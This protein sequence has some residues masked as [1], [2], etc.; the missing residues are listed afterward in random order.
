M[1]P[2][3]LPALSSKKMAAFFHFAIMNMGAGVNINIA[4][5]VQ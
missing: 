1:R 4:S 2:Q 3:T 5:A